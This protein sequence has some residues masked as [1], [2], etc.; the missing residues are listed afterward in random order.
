MSACLHGIVYPNQVIS[1]FKFGTDF[2]ADFVAFGAFSG[3]CCFHFVE[4]E[5]PG[6]RLFT[7]NGV[8]AK[9]FN[10]ALAQISAWKIF[11]EKHREEVLRELAKVFSQRELV[12]GRK[13]EEPT[14]TTGMPLY[15]PCQWIV[16]DYHIVIG[17]RDSLSKAELGKKSAYL[18]QAEVDVMT[19]DRLLDQARAF[20]EEPE[21]GMHDRPRARGR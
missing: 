12:F 16:W 8:A 18:T 11:V 20:D 7:Q 10:G 1:Q 2:V 15:D 3:A 4:L 21:T 9:R 13:G 5:P 19:Y 6:E 17:R 14:D